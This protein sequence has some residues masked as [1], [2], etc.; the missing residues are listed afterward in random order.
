MATAFQCCSVA[1]RDLEAAIERFERFFGL[2]QTTGISEQRWG[3]RG[4]CLNLH[5]QAARNLDIPRAK[6]DT[7]SAWWE[8]DLHMPAKIAALPYT[9]A[10]T[11]SADTT[12]ANRFATYHADLAAHFTAARS[13]TSSAS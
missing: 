3:F 5:F 13:P 1:V 9:E 4:W 7:H 10:L 11:R 2:K 12:V 6:I 8:T